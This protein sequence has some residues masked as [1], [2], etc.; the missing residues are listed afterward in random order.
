MKSYCAMCQGDREMV[1]PKY[2]EREN[3]WPYTVGRCS[4]CNRALWVIHEEEPNGCA[5]V[6]ARSH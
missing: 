6:K 1:N 2:F 3:D 4:G 5:S